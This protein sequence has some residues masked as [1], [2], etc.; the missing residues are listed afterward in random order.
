MSK[1]QHT[2][3]IEGR[4]LNVDAKNMAEW[5]VNTEAIGE[6]EADP[7]AVADV[8]AHALRK[9]LGL[10]EG[11]TRKVRQQLAAEFQQL[12]TLGLDRPHRPNDGQEDWYA[13][14]DRILLE[15]AA[16]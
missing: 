14:R 12:Q 8:S 4:R 7:E 10:D 2:A 15:A 3:Q 1:A 6:L 9:A 11:A 5:L 13:K 16:H